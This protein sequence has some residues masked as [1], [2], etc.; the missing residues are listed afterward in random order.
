M[1]FTWLSATLG[2][3][4]YLAHCGTQSRRPAWSLLWKLLGEVSETRLAVSVELYRAPVKAKEA[5]LTHQ[6]C[7]AEELLLH[8]QPCWPNFQETRDSDINPRQFLADDSLSP[9]RYSL[10]IFFLLSIIY[11]AWTK[12]LVLYISGVYCGTKRMS[13]S[14]VVYSRSGLC[15]VGR[16]YRA[17]LSF[18]IFIFISCLPG[19]F[20]IL[21]RYLCTF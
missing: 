4:P 17:H 18:F 20:I 12:K 21:W 7:W 5:L 15:G 16:L 8:K 2:S 3:V 11:S 9:L 6:G 14:C 13:A 10:Q 19:S 1:R